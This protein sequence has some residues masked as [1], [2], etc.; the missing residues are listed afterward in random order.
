MSIQDHRE[1]SCTSQ[2]IQVAS[3]KLAADLARLNDAISRT[4]E[5]ICNREAARLTDEMTMDGTHDSEAVDAGAWDLFVGAGHGSRLAA[6]RRAP[7]VMFRSGT[8]SED[9]A[10]AA[11]GGVDLSQGGSRTRRE[12][13]R[14]RQSGFRGTSCRHHCP[15]PAL[16]PGTPSGH[17]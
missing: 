16:L 2:P 7:V 12:E 1:T 15:R 10:D 13:S 6:P 4:F 5:V 14:F 11:V 17:D 8:A 3:A 9:S